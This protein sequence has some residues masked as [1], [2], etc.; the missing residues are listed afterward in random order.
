MELILKIVSNNEEK[1]E[2][3]YNFDSVPDDIFKKPDVNEYEI[4]EKNSLC[5]RFNIHL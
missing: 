5:Y 4:I 1:K 3:E 2:M